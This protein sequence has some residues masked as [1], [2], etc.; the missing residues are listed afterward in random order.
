MQFLKVA[1]D[2]DRIEVAM[3]QLYEWLAEQQ[4]GDPEAADLFLHLRL[5]EV[6]HRNIIDFER[7][8]AIDN[9][10]RFRIIGMDAQG[11]DEAL[12]SVGRFRELHPRPSLVQ[13]LQIALA[14]EQ[15]AAELYYQSLGGRATAEFSRLIAHLHAGCRTHFGKIVDFASNRGLPV[16]LDESFEIG[17]PAKGEPT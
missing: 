13:S 4:A 10:D 14:L 12:R 6:S 15:S 16:H 1:S 11:L 7:R 17:A 5:E 8:V 3:C 2:L 9:P